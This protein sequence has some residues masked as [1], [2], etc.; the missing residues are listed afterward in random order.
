MGHGNKVAIK[1]LMKVLKKLSDIKGNKMH[2]LIFPIEELEFRFGS[3]HKK[4]F[5]TKMSEAQQTI[6]EAIK[7]LY[8]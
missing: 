6:L 3:D 5:H 2:F 1:R 4:N 7:Y 8:D